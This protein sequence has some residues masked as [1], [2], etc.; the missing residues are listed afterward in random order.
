VLSLLLA[1]LAEFI[2]LYLFSDEFLVL[3]GPVIYAFAITAG[4]FYKSILGHGYR[5]IQKP[6]KCN[7]LQL[8][9]YGFNLF[10]E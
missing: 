10:L 1:P 5:L 4:E 9:L 8:Y 2:K 3:A 6:I 7:I